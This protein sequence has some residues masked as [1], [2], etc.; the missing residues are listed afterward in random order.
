M[1][2]IRQDGKVLRVA[3]ETAHTLVRLGEAEYVPK[4]AWKAER[5]GKRTRRETP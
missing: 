4:S 5:P 3:D 2:C 1:K